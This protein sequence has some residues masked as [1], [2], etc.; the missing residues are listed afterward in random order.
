MPGALVSI[1]NLSLNGGCLQSLEA[2]PTQT[3]TNQMW[4]EVFQDET[5][6]QG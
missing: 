3:N 2:H 4:L 5:Y 6:A 1:N